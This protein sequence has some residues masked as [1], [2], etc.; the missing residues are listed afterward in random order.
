MVTSPNN[1]PEGPLTKYRKLASFDWNKMKEFITGNEILT[2]E[3]RFHEKLLKHPFLYEESLTS[4]SLSEQRRI[5]AKKLATLNCIVKNLMDQKSFSPLEL[6]CFLNNIFAMDV[7]LGIQYIVNFSIFSLSVQRMGTERHQEVF[8]KA[9]SG[10][11]YGAICY[12]EVAHGS[13]SM[14]LRTTATYDLNKKHFILHTPD[15]KAAKCYMCYGLSATYGIVYAKLI[16]PNGKNCGLHTFLVTL[17][18]SALNLYPGIK[19]ADLQDK[20]GAN[21]LD[22]GII[23]FDHYPVPRERLLNKVGDV[24]EDG[25]YIANSTENVQKNTLQTFIESRL[26]VAAASIAYLVKSLT[27]AIRYAAVRRQFSPN[28]EEEEF[29]LIE[30]QTHQCRLFPYLSLAYCSKIFSEF[31]YTITYST[32]ASYE[33]LYPSTSS[34]KCVV[35]WLA[36]SGI[37]ECR[38]ACGG[39]GYLKASGIGNMRNGSDLNTT[40]EGDNHVMLQQA[41]TWLLQQWSLVLQGQ[42]ITSSFKTVELLNNAKQ[43]LNSKFERKSTEETLSVEDTLNAFNW[44]FCYTLKLTYEKYEMLLKQHPST[45]A[46]FHAK[47]NSQ[48]FYAKTLGMVYA[49]HLLLSTMQLKISKIP[50]FT[51]LKSTLLNL[52]NL[53]GCWLLEK[54]VGKLYSGGYFTDARPPIMLEETILKLCVKLKNEAVAL[55]D[56]IAHPD[57]II[58]SVSGYADGEVYKHFEEAF[59]SVK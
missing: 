1:L 18:D 6:L 56:A 38:E 54:H 10:E 23:I 32:E 2:F 5:S 35:T 3:Q 34:I 29:E 33:E 51:P 14:G 59:F 45:S 44:L 26:R 46:S 31:I 49:Q 17:R 25:Q 19:T 12:T 37:Q 50:T 4:P 41:S 40:S 21:G 47:N 8:E 58:N 9:M 22:N 53:L 7:S 57:F 13:N 24:T 55:I 30:Y 15:F 28:V 48:V 11:V 39:Y 36:N 42:V 43:I 52:L 16:L 27:I 20:C